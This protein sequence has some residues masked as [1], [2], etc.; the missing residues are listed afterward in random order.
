LPSI[1]SKR[2]ETPIPGSPFA[3]DDTDYT[4]LD[5]VDP[6]ETG[7][8]APLISNPE[9]LEIFKKINE[10]NQLLAS[11]VD[12]EIEV[13]PEPPKALSSSTINTA[14]SSASINNALNELDQTIREQEMTLP[15]EADD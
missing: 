7:E 4:I 3:Q 15:P 6:Q 8:E 1:K 5:S 11:N 2:V 9:E 14:I 13:V 10:I 12:E